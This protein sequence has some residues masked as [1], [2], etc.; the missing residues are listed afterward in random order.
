[1]SISHGTQ[2]ILNI[3]GI[4]LL[5]LFCAFLAKVYLIPFPEPSSPWNGYRVYAFVTGSE[6]KL[7][8]EEFEAVRETFAQHGYDEL[9]H[10]RSQRV[11]YFTYEG[12]REAELSAIRG[13]FEASDPLYDPY[14]RGVGKYF[15]GELHG[16]DAELIYVPSR[17]ASLLDD[18]R[19][20]R[21]LDRL[22]NEYAVSGVFPKLRLIGAG[23]GLF[24]ALLFLLPLR[25]RDFILYLAGLVPLVLGVA[26]SL[27]FVISQS[28][29]LMVGWALFVGISRGPLCEYVDI[30]SS[31]SRRSIR[32]GVIVYAA[33][34]AGSLILSAFAEPE[35]RTLLILQQAMAVA[36][37]ISVAGFYVSFR[38]LKSRRYEHLPFYPEHI[39]RRNE[40]LN[41]GL[42]G[43]AVGVLLVMSL[44]PLVYSAYLSRSGE[45]LLPV[46][47]DLASLN[48]ESI[49]GELGDRQGET[50]PGGGH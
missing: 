37:Q 36:A 23:I 32:L 13:R 47:I 4:S 3:L 11:R 34:S 12:G 26:S 8:R 31:R 45:I 38:M 28:F 22:G 20:H 27:F 42:R 2:R 24:A 19:L 21:A 46:P 33:F 25:R 1:M 18:Y 9:L 35:E 50:A 5:V 29:L 49:S 48:E 10:R 41:P 15:S 44:F 43:T 39:R 14:M 16:Q 40:S 17:S 7:S 30:G 6:E